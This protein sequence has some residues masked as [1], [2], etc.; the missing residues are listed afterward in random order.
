MVSPYLRQP[1]RSLEE[2]KRELKRRAAKR[3]NKNVIWICGRFRKA[4]ASRQAAD[5][6]P[7]NRT[8]RTDR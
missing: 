1:L 6:H 7:R 8:D 3:R 4:V 5:S 2:A